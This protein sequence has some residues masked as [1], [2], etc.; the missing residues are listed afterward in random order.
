MNTVLIEEGDV[1]ASHDVVSLFTNTPIDK[2]MEVIQERLEADTSLSER[3]NLEAHDVI[4]LLKFVLTTPYS[5]AKYTNRNLA[6]PWV[7][8]YHPLLQTCT[9]SS[10]NRMP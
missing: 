6:Q 5:G 9:W 7:V 10:L 3:T 8:Q 2:S 1:L 4:E